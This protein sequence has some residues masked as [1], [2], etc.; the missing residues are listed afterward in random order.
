MLWVRLQLRR[1]QKILV[2]IF[3]GK[4]ETRTNLEKEYETI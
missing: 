2:G 4:Q 1:H 3:Y